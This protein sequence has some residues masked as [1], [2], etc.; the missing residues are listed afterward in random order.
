MKVLDT[1]VVVSNVFFLTCLVCQS[2][3]YWFMSYY[4][5]CVLPIWEE[6]TSVLFHKLFFPHD[7]LVL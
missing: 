7:D 4:T 5:L 1:Q 3:A 2:L 6:T